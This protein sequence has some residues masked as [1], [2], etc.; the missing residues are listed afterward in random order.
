V[1]RMARLS[2]GPVRTGARRCRS[3]PFRECTGRAE[4]PAG[5]FDEAWLVCGRRAGKSFILALIACYLAV[6]RDWRPYLAPGEVGMIRSSP[7]TVAKPGSFIGIAGRGWVRFRRSASWWRVMVTMRS[8]SRTASSLTSRRPVFG[9]SAD[10]PLS[11]PS[12][13]KSPIGPATNC[14]RIPTAEYSLR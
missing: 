1:N 8:S 2:G 14:Q 7:R 12:V 6:F 5:G 10:T 13:M 4:P 3:G 11:R 9:W